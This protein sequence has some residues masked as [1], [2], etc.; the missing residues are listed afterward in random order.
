MADTDEKS[1]LFRTLLNKIP[2]NMRF[3]ASDL[4]GGDSPATN[5]NFTEEQL[6][7]MK[8]TAAN[9]IKEGKDS[10][11]Y[12]DYPG[13]EMNYNQNLLDKMKD[14][15]FQMRSTIGSANIKINDD[16]EVILTDQF[17]FNDAKDVNSLNDLRKAMIDILGAKGAYNKL[18]KIG[19]YFGSP[20]GE[21]SPIELNLG[22]L[23]V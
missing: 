11:S 22:Q 7:I 21:G 12:G 19:T 4:L 8:T 17:N 6:G 18:R 20:E 10:L 3:F 16:G 23:N 2:A 1:S 13:G 14:P 9:A 15:N 5:E